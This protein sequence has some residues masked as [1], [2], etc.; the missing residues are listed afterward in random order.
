MSPLQIYNTLTREKQVFKPLRDGEVGLYVC[1]VTV[2]DYCHIGH[3][4]S[5]IAFDMITRY[6]RHL[7]YC[8]NYVRNITDIEDKIIHRANEYNIAFNDVV[9]KFTQ[10]MHEDFA[11]LNILSPTSEPRATDC[12][13]QIIAMV[14]GLIDKGVAYVADNGDVYYAVDKFAHYGCLS[15]QSINDLRA[16]ERIAIETAKRDPLDFVLWKQSKPGEPSWPSP[17]GAGRP[18]WHIECSAMSTHYLGDQ[19]DIHGGG[20]DLK[21]PHHENEIAQAMAASDQP[22]ANLW[23]HIGL[24]QVNKEKMSKSLGNFFTIREVL[25]KHHPEVIRYFMLA[26]HYRSPINYSV[27]NLAN[28]KAALMRLYTALRGIH[29]DS[30]IVLDEEYI[31]QFQQAMNDDFNTPVAISIMFDLARELNS[32]A[33]HAAR[34]T[35]LAATL[36]HLGEILGL[37]QCNPEQFLQGDTDDTQWIEQLIAER[38]QAREDKDWSKADQIRQQLSDR[39]ITI[40]DSGH[41]T[42]WRRV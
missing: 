33:E 39:G 28:A 18:G 30:S 14:Q 10:V 38:Q 36:L 19:F 1:G 3:A 37:L 34:A 29:I 13:P 31:Q 4:R 17:W 24:L 32:Q 26:S 8:V 20:L 5:Y 22:F 27:D 41:S 42:L 40:E 2:Y 16:G 6:L 21:F 7:G 23:M 12:M 25:E 9:A 11:A 35:Q 15:Q